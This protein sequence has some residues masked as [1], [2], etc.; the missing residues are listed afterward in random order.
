MGQRCLGRYRLAKIDQLAIHLA[1]VTD[2]VQNRAANDL[3]RSATQYTL[4]PCG[5]AR[6]D[7]G[8]CQ[9]PLRVADRL[10]DRV[11]L[12]SWCMKK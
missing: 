7:A 6:A 11:R 1:V 3:E 2:D 9:T 12:T 4:L 5:T 10:W 8:H